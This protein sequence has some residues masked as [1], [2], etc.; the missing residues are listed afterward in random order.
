MCY[1]ILIQRYTYHIEKELYY[2]YY[3]Y[4]NIPLIVY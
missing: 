3:Q 4:Y 2:L 1:L